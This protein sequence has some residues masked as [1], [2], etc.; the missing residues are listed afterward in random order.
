MPLQEFNKGIFDY[1]IAADTKSVESE[2]TE[3][4]KS[5]DKA[6]SKKEKAEARK[7]KR[8]EDEE[9]GVT[10]GVDFKGVETVVNIDA[11]SRVDM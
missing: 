7:R 2:Q 6:S 3:P 10:R 5:K 9:F 1:L 4:S 8:E 11:P